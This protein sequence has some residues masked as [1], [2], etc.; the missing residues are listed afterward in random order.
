[1]RSLGADELIDYRATDFA[2]QVRDVD[3][4]LE[5]VGGDY[6]ERSLRTLRPGG[7]FVT[8]VGRTDTE[9]ARKTRSAGMKFVGISVE[10]DYAGL[11]ALARLAETGR[12]RVHLAA[13]YPLA[14][15][16]EAHRFL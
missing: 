12:L 11:E 4:V 1:V 8:I 10:P 3:V 2:E 5:S 9:L 14:Q 13:A 15:A 7:Q 16:A 6:G